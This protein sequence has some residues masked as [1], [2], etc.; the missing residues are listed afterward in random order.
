MFPVNRI[1]QRSVLTRNQEWIIGTFVYLGIDFIFVVRI[2]LL[3]LNGECNPSLH[4]ASKITSQ[5]IKLYLN[6]AVF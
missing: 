1:L 3:F 6:P 2:S 4:L 5:G